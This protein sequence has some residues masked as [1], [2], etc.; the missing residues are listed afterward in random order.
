VKFR[1]NKKRGQERRVWRERLGYYIPFFK[2]PQLD[3]GA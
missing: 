1:G 3:C 2:Q